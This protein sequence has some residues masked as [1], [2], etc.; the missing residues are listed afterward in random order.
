[1]RNLISKNSFHKEK[2]IKFDVNNTYYCMWARKRRGCL[3]VTL[4]FWS[5]AKNVNTAIHQFRVES[6]FLKISQRAQCFNVSFLAK[7][8]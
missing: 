4:Q 2:W 3:L 8:E 1:M 6:M 7:R 5:L